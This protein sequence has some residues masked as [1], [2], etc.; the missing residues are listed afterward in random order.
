V[1]INAFDTASGAHPELQALLPGAALLV[2]PLLRADGEPVGVLALRDALEPERFD[3]RDLEQVRLFATQATIAIETARLH[4]GMRVAR[5][6]AEA[7][8]ARWRA[9]VDN[10]P[11]LVMT[12]DTAGRITFLNAAYEQLAGQAAD[13]DVQVSETANFYGISWPE[14]SDAYPMERLPL[15][16]ALNENEVVRGM[17]LLQRTYDGGKR[18]IAWDAAP[19][20]GPDGTP[21]GAIAV[22]RDITEEQRRG[23]RERCLMA[24]MRAAAGSA[25]ARGES[26]RVERALRTLV[27]HSEMAMLATALY[28]YDEERGA[29]TRAGS[30]GL[31]TT[32]VVPPAVPLDSRHRWWE[33]VTRGPM[34]SSED[35]STPRW[36][37]DAAPSVWR[38][39][40]RRAWATVP[41]HS[42]AT[43]LGV[44][45]VGLMTPHVW[46]D[47]ERE[48][49]EA[50]AGAVTLALTNDRLYAAARRRADELETV[51]NTVD[52]GI[53]MFSA[54]GRTL[55]RNPAAA[56]ITE[57]P[58]YTG[59][60]EV[61]VSA[62]GLRDGLTG[63]PL[64]LED[65][66]LARALRGER[67][68][69]ALI[70]MRDGEGRDRLTRS[71]SAPV[72][73]V[74]GR[75]VAAVTVF[76]E[77]PRREVLGERLGQGQ[78]QGQGEELKTVDVGTRKRKP[79]GGAKGQGEQQRRGE[80]EGRGL[81]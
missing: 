54:D 62:Y 3:E 23:D 18:L 61:A 66:P 7:E 26:S 21:L 56:A 13:A 28:T 53:T 6:E 70:V 5:Q 40:H 64:P 15:H 46:D 67:V 59:N 33:P 34:Y 4:E 69:D 68:R 24:V 41:L 27:E 73:D 42:G 74:T 58:E 43:F 63:E 35:G 37:M 60:L 29:L 44:L 17:E 65:S 45:A 16:R 57:R 9:I 78:G 49:L 12:C 77:V 10:A 22:G 1:I 52:V 39:T 51:L 19:V 75:V 72:R 11:E 25:R 30:Y 55:V 80:A 81:D 14:G 50:C 36:L 48:W 2:A 31:E 71:S 8:R 47:A 38:Y 79:K 76:S 20:H 32:R